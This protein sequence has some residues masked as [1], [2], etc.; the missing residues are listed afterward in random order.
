MN[1]STDQQ[2]NIGDSR[3]QGENVI[4]GGDEGMDASARLGKAG[5]GHEYNTLW[6]GL[7]ALKETVSTTGREGRRSSITTDWYWSASLLCVTR[8]SWF[9]VVWAAGFLHHR[10]AVRTSGATFIKV[11]TG[12]KCAHYVRIFHRQRRPHGKEC[13]VLCILS[14][15]SR[16]PA[17]FYEQKSPETTAI[18]WWR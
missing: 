14:P 5:H 2:I 16:G 8:R 6:A 4:R 15:R 12:R 7:T 18:S 3:N 11:E 10:P 17:K 13:A 1:T 9:Y